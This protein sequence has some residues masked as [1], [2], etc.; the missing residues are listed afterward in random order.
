M[1]ISNILL[2]YILFI[3]IILIITNISVTKVTHHNKTLNNETLNNDIT[4]TND[5]PIDNATFDNETNLLVP[6]VQIVYNPNDVNRP[7]NEL[8]HQMIDEN[9]LESKVDQNNILVNTTGDTPLVF[10]LDEL[11]YIQ[12]APSD[13]QNLEA[14]IKPIDAGSGIITIDLANNNNKLYK[15]KSLR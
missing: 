3:L 1:N 15:L 8:P 6:D 7:A 5:K 12:Q 10:S 14:S 9:E 11:T 4:T 13:T 2:L